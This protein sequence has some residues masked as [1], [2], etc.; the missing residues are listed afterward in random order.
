MSTGLPFEPLIKR[1]LVT[2]IAKAIFVT[3]GFIFLSGTIFLAWA[4]KT[5]RAVESVRQQLLTR[6]HDDCD[7]NASF[8]TLSLDPIEAQLSLTDLE[9]KQLD[10][11]PLLSVQAALVSLRILPLFY[12]RVQLD[13]VAVLGP[14]ARV[15]VKEG[16]VQSLPR[17]IPVEGGGD[18]KV[19][20]GIRELTIERGR[21]DLE[22]EDAQVNA[23]VR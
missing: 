12:G 14:E 23:V 9:L 6:L 22:I 10:G 20:L 1:L 19:V 18:S 21:F 13:R 7:L 16:K 17:C 4:F 5:G 3:L 2:R 11:K 15:V 8:T